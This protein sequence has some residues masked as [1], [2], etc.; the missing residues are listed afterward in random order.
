M[1]DCVFCKIS[2]GQLP[3]YKVYEDKDYLGFLDILPLTP[4]HTLLIPKVHC[5]WVDDVAEFGEYFEAAKKIGLAQRKILGAFTVHYLTLGFEIPHA[6]IRIVPRFEND[7]HGEKI[8]WD[9]AHKLADDQMKDI[10]QK[11]RKELL[12]I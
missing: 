6:H 11:L 12:T 2:A 4:G 5:R 3:I 1:E 10:A 7:G 9:L 8:N